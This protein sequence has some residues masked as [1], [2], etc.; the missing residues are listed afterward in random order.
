MYFINFPTTLYQLYPAARGKP[1]EYVAMI[2]IT[3]NVRFKKEVIDNIVLYD[4]YVMKE[5]DTI[6][7]TSERL[8]G[9]PYYHWVLMLLNER[10][11]YINDFPRNGDSFDSYV[12]NEYKAD[13]LQEQYDLTPESLIIDIRNDDGRSVELDGTYQITN[14]NTNAVTSVDIFSASK[15]DTTLG[16]PIKQF[17]NRSAGVALDLKTYSV[18][19]GA[20]P[21]KSPVYAY[22]EEFMKNEE[23]RKI[24]IITNELLQTVLLNFKELL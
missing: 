14:R 10:Y 21:D 22:N 23:K 1:A 24:K 17:Y 9:T 20:I 13:Y 3:R 16:K 7:T 18:N 4:Y 11:D 5:F 12:T 6:E 8:Y 19:F 2:D 15:Y